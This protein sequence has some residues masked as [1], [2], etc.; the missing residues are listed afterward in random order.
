VE[1]K[2]AV[3]THTLSEALITAAVAGLALIA[4]NVSD[5]GRNSPSVAVAQHGNTNC[6]LMDGKV[7][8]TPRTKQGIK[9]TS[10]ASF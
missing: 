8:C 3:M 2:E 9:L 7:R 1:I 5:V 6:V 10:S 4:C